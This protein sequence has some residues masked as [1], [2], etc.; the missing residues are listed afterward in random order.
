MMIKSILPAVMFSMVLGGCSDTIRDIGRPPQLSSVGYGLP[1]DR[2]SDAPIR[3]AK[4]RHGSPFSTWNNRGGDLFSD[5][6]ALQPGDILTVQIAINDQAQLTNRSDSKRT[7]A[8]A[9]NLRCV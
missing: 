5:K 2:L 1:G 6:L 7:G 8:G 3:S 4:S 9:R